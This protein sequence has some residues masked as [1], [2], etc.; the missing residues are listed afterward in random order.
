[1]ARSARR[2]WRVATRWSRPTSTAA[3]AASRT[4]GMMAAS[5]HIRRS[6][7]TGRGVPSAVSQMPWSCR[8]VRSVSRS[9][10]TITSGV[11]RPPDVA[12][13]P[14][15]RVIR[16]T[17]ASVSASSSRCVWQT[18]VS[19][20]FHR[21]TLRLRRLR[22]S[23]DRPSSGD[24]NR[25][26][27]RTSRSNASTGIADALA[28]RVGCKPAS[29]VRPDAS[30]EAAARASA[31]TCPAASCPAARAVWTSGN[32]SQTFARRAA[33]A[34]SRVERRPAAASTSATPDA[35]IGLEVVDALGD[36]D[37]VGV[38]PRPHPQ[39]G[40]HQGVELRRGRTTLGRR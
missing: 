34:A 7:A 32:R 31:S 25:A 38:E 14:C 36:A 20:S 16:S 33:A 4:T 17:S 27:R 3:P 21:R 37:V 6:E 8:P 18:P 12:A 22:S 5:Q 35:T 1:M 10:S 26:S 9:M 2:W 23:S 15:G 28:M 29:S 11:G 24:S 13:S 30:S 40:R 19:P 39:R